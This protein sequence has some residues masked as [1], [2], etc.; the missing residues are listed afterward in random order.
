MEWYFALGILNDILDFAGVDLA[1]FRLNDLITALII[2]R[3]VFSKETKSNGLTRW[4]F[5]AL[6][7]EL[8]PFLGEIVPGWSVLSF[9]IN[10]LIKNKVIA[11]ND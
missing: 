11:K 1:L 2:G 6:G 7:I 5:F 4:F 10:K 8:V 9:I 3:K